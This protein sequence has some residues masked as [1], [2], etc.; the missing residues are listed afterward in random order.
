[1]ADTGGPGADQGIQLERP[2][3][4]QGGGDVA[5]VHAANRGEDRFDGRVNI[6]DDRAALEESFDVQDDLQ[7]EGGHMGQRGFDGLS[8]DPS[9]LSNELGE[10]VVAVGN[11]IYKPGQV[12]FPFDDRNQPQTGN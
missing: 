4:A 12:C 10:L 2:H 8:I 11:L 7:G 1:M 3:R 9:G 6:I 5:M